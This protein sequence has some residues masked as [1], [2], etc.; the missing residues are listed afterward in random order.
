MWY[1]RI[2]RTENVKFL[3][4]GSLLSNQGIPNVVLRLYF[5]S[6][7]LF[8]GIY[9]NASPLSVILGLDMTS[10]HSD[11]QLKCSWKER[12]LIQGLKWSPKY[13]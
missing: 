3:L 10:V 11:S 2:V 5:S 7:H 8:V 12:L 9:S 1:Y 6:L 13:L 4:P